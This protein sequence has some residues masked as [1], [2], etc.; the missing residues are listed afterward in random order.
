MTPD[1]DP[2]DLFSWHLA[3]CIALAI[4]LGLVVCLIA[5][6]LDGIPSP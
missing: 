5:G 4:L 1:D 2:T 6:W 3:D